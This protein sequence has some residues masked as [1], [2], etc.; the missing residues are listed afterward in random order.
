MDSTVLGATVSSVSGKTST[1]ISSTAKRATSQGASFEDMLKS[2][3]QQDS[4]GKID[5]EQLYAALINERLTTKIGADAGS[6]Y[7]NLLKT[8]KHD[9]QWENG[10][11]PVEQSAG[12]ALQELVDQ[13]VLDRAEAESINA[14]AFKAAQLDDNTAALYDS[15]GSTVA[16]GLLDLA[17]QSAREVTASFDSGGEEA[18]TVAIRTDFINSPAD[19][20]G[21]GISDSAS[22]VGGNGF[23]Y[24]PVS[25]SNGNL[26]VLLPSSMRRNVQLV[27]LLDSSKNILETGDA[28]DAFEDG[29]PIF[30]FDKPGASYPDGLVV[31][32]SLDNGEMKEYKIPDSSKR[33]S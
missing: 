11:V 29:R 12:K 21:S 25:E 10:Y 28:K 8:Y 30:R 5:E 17:I 16:V 1:S 6:T 2:L 31:R 24:K 20:R 23:L 4:K 22:F 9:L 18:G 27:Q 19:G 14:Q 32:V 7:Q 13:G 26:V 33:Y 3:M 15:L